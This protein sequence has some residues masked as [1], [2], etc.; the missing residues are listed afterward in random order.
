MGAATGGLDQSAS[1]LATEGHALLLDC[2]DFSTVSVPWDL[3][4]QGLALLITD[5]R[6][7]H[8]LVGGEY[9][10]RRAQ[11]EV[12]AR[13]LGVTT[14]RDVPLENIDGELARI[15][16]PL[17][18]CRARH[19]LTEIART[20]A[21][22]DL[23]ETGAVREKAGEL[24]EL[25]NASHTSLRDDFAVT[26]P[27]LNVAV[28][29]ARHAGAHGARMTGGGFGGSIIALVEADQ[30]EQVARAIDAAFTERG[31]TAPQSF[32]ALPSAGA[33]RDS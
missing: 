2:R 25:M 26:V 28:E 21:F 12:A 13:T 10:E 3:A 18:H 27:E 9:A 31:F 7:P 29:A 15:E 24:G 22:A 11:A 23:L 33:G 19:V 4:G 32:L 6:A 30:A 1:I 20:R 17:I 14:R 8:S 5:T 16:D